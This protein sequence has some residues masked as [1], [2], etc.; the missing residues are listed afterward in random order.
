MISNS[1]Q[2]YIKS[3]YIVSRFQKWD[4]IESFECGL[5][6]LLGTGAII[7]FFVG[8]RY[9][10]RGI[11]FTDEGLYLHWLHDPWQY[12]TSITQFGFVYHLFY[13]ITGGSIYGMR[14]LSF[15][16]TG[17][18]F[19]TCIVVCLRECALGLQ[20]TVLVGIG[21]CSAILGDLRLWLPTPSY[22][23]LNL[24]GILVCLLGLLLSCQKTRQQ[25]AWTAGTAIGIGGFLS[26]LAKPPT[27][28]LLCFLVLLFVILFSKRKLTVLVTAGLVAV[29]LLLLTALLIDG[30]VLSH[31]ERYE[32][33]LSFVGL[34]SADHDL[35]SM[36]GR[37]TLRWP[38]FEKQI[39]A[40]ILAGSAVMTLFGLR[41]DSPVLRSVWIVVLAIAIVYSVLVSLEPEQTMF[42]RNSIIQPAFLWAVD[43]GVIGAI[44]VESAIARRNEVN[45]ILPNIGVFLLL[46]LLP[47]VYSFGGARTLW[48]GAI[49]SYAIVTLLAVKVIV[50]MPNVERVRAAST[51]LAVATLL[52]SAH[53]AMAGSLKPYR[54]SVALGEQEIPVRL[55]PDGAILKLSKGVA[56]YLGSLQEASRSHGFRAGQPIIDLTGRSPGVVF[57]LG[58]T[59]PGTPWLI[60]G[61]PGSGL[62]LKAFL[63]RVP[64]DLLAAA[65]VLDVQNGRLTLPK[66]ILWRYGLNLAGD[67]EL[68]AEVPSPDGVGYHQ[69]LRPLRTPEIAQKLCETSKA[70]IQ[71]TARPGL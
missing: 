64:C 49:G 3:A 19:L 26:W 16:I 59:A 51:T 9:F 45:S 57:A 56:A 7:L 61:Y 54:Q 67:F 34:L 30:S 25:G 27:A 33:G 10:G 69:L 29:L 17:S 40:G 4:L 23:S 36:F 24:Q 63:D 35:G 39:F 48:Q 32:R 52:V 15:L 31:I 53:L 1:F 28:I 60:S 55:G 8:V 22:N 71:G 6:I 11:D 18:I 43:F 62:W 47:L 21:L 2:Q 41:R 38:T 50:S 13:N 42:K 37:F 46:L 70:T 5:R 44:V 20:S 12:D 58:G 66:G 65:W 68:V 14:C